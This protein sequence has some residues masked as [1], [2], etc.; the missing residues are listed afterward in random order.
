MMN[1][2]DII[3]ALTPLIDA[4]ERF[5]VP[6][7]IGGSVASSIHGKRR[8]TQDVDLI[9]ALQSGHIWPLVRLLEDEYYIDQDMIQDALRRQS[10]F[11]VLHNETGIKIDVFV[12]QSNQFSQQELQ[13]AREE[14]LDPGSRLFP[15][16]SPED[17]V[18]RKLHWWKMGGGASTRQW[19]DLVEVLKRQALTLDLAY[20]RQSAP[21]LD[22][23]THLEDALADAGLSQ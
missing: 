6:Y 2:P 1:A 16:A 3:Q 12:L 5:N 14:V 23:S 8:A 10:S 4:F 9:A 11:N 13:R 17:V 18:L 22:I 7:Y 19:N 15:V 21:L 20:L